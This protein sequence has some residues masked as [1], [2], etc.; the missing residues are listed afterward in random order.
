M[1]KAVVKNAN[2]RIESDSAQ[3]DF[4]RVYINDE[5]QKDIR[6]IV[7]IAE[8]GCFNQVEVHR[9]TPGKASV[10][11]KA[12]VVEKNEEKNNDKM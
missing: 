2:I 8:V 7:F 1:K 3:S 5:L 6:K 10:N 11:A 4:L 9:T 12:I